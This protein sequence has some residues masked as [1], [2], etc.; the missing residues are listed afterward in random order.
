MTDPHE[1]DL[2]AVDAAARAASRGLAA[3]VASRVEP[4]IALASLPAITPPRAWSR[5][6]AVAA[7]VVLALGSAAVLD[8]Q[9]GDGRSRLELDD[10][11]NPLPL[12]TPGVLTPL[13]PRDGKDSIG[14][15]VTVEPNQGLGDGDTLTVTGSGF[16]AGEQV[17]IVQCAREAGGE[18]RETRGGVDGCDIGS[19]AYA[20]AGDDGVAVGR[21]T[22]HRVLTTPLTGTVDCAAEAERCV[23]GMGALD[24]YDRSGGFALTF[25]GGGEPVDI[26]AIGVEPAEGLADGGVVRVRGEG[27]APHEVAMVTVC[28]TD[29]F[30]CWGTNG[31]SHSFGVQADGD[32]RV[33]DEV[34]VYRFLPGPDGSTY[35]D[36]AISPCWLRVAGESAPPPVRLT[37][38][39]EE[40]APVP[41]AVAVDPSEG[42]APGDTLVVRGAGFP[43]NAYVYLSLCAGPVGGGPEAARQACWSG[44]SE[45]IEI[46][47]DGSFAV[48]FEVPDLQSIDETMGS[49]TTSC[50]E[51]DCG[52]GA[53]PLTVA[54]DG[55]GTSCALY[56]DVQFGDEDQQHPPT[57]APAP[58]PVTFRTQP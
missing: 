2:T 6:L 45:S 30:A 13:G 48:E 22:V 20:D 55:V 43:A 8:N 12:P 33:D 23:I 26:P 44:D 3:H 50:A 4:E 29:P 25:V 24:D 15:P 27:F 10:D 53:E 17:G 52:G 21:I 9:D 56:V 31:R 7:V 5:L 42:L 35:I 41:P 49:V 40:P 18:T 34:P 16:V 54:C 38:T 19:V 36:C 14:L 57:F 46:D 51:G 58:V 39:G 1:P 28:S 37:F 32:G 47:S 11:G